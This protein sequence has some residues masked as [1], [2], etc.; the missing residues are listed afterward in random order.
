MAGRLFRGQIGWE[1]YRA[2]LPVEPPPNV[3]P[4]ERQDM[5]FPG[6]V[7]PIIRHV[8]EGDGP[9][10]TAL[11]LGPVVWGLIPDWFRGRPEEWKAPAI[12]ARG[13]EIAH[14]PLFRGAFRHR[15]CLVPAHG[16]YVF[17]GPKGRK[18]RY[19]VARPDGDWLCFAGVW[20]RALMDG[21]SRDG[22]ALVTTTPNDAVAA[23]SM[24]MPVIIAPEDYR[25]WLN[26][27]LHAAQMLLTS[28]PVE[29][30]CV[31]PSLEGYP[32]WPEG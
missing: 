10:R 17:E 7:L 2:R 30:T 25:T 12:N 32:A 11:E 14:K 6:T 3:D 9:D 16:Y 15:R 22:A 27:S 20:E 31:W 26:G 29:E 4:P 28:S 24:R 23:L 1:D 13:E 5:I 19:A 21:T 8:P 18:T